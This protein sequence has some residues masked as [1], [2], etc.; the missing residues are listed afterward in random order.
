MDREWIWCDTLA[1]FV[2]RNQGWAYDAP[3]P[4]IAWSRARAQRDAR[5]RR[6]ALL[7]ATGGPELDRAME[8]RREER[9]ADDDRRE[10]MH[11]DRRAD[12]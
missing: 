6:A 3:T 4:E 7:A 10:S 2:Q 8:L 5:A 9:L 1:E 12:R 11:H